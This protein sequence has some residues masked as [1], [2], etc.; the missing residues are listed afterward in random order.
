MAIS[1]PTGGG[2]EPQNEPNVVPMI[3]ILLVLLIIF[4][5]QVPM[6][7]MAVDAQIPPEQR[8]QQESQ[9]PSNNIVLQLLADGTIPS[10]VLAPIYTAF[11]FLLIALM[12]VISIW[13]VKRWFFS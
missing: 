2:T 12:V 9:G 11:M 3:D 8:S 4:M 13:D 6:N 5:M 7:R 10:R 1:L